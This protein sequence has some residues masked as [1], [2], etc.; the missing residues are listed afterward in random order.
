MNTNRIARLFRRKPMHFAVAILLSIVAASSP[1]Q[2]AGPAALPNVDVV[3]LRNQVRQFQETLN[4]DLQAT[5]EH[6]FALLQDVK[7]T[8]LPRYGVVFHMELNLAPLRALSAFDLRPYT[9]QEL[10][11]AREAKIERIR[12]LKDQL[13]N[14]LEQHGGEFAAMPPD[15]SIAIVVHLFNLPSERTDGLPTQVGVEVS[16]SVLADAAA[17]KAPAEEFRKEVSFFDF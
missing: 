1:A 5:F 13:S 4:R 7:G 6:P 16:R 14:L 3:A 15:Q 8:Y 12:Q 10:R 17:R 2:A 11:Q 9:E